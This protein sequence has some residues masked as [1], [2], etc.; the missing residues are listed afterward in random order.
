VTRVVRV[1]G[2]QSSKEAGQE[3]GQAVLLTSGGG[4]VRGGCPG[5]QRG[6][7]AGERRRV[8]VRYERHQRTSQRGAS[9][10]RRGEC[11]QW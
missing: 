11:G 1:R 3:G 10:N 9:D 8:L 4:T 6:E 2:D 5:K 7:G